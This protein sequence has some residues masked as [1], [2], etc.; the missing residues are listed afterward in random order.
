MTKPSR[1]CRVRVQ[2]Y[3]RN[4][5]PDMREAKPTVSSRK[6][7]GEMR[8]RFT[9]RK[10]LHSGDGESFQQIVHLTTDEVGNVTKV[11]VSR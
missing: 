5:F 4:H 1:K 8:H 11:S 2:K 9:F 3:V 6:Y 10:T 7:A